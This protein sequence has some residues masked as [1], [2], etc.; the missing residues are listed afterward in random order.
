MECF[1]LIFVHFFPLLLIWFS[2]VSLSLSLSLNLL[3]VT[4]YLMFFGV[5]I[6]LNLS[7]FSGR[8]TTK[9]R[10]KFMEHTEIK[11]TSQLRTE[12][13]TKINKR[14]HSKPVFSCTSHSIC[15]I[16]IIL[17]SVCFVPWCTIVEHFH[18][19]VEHFEMLHFKFRVFFRPV[20]SIGAEDGQPLP[21]NMKRNNKLL[22]TA[23]YLWCSKM[24]CTTS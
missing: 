7:N 15:V 13:Q 10:P 14:Y 17:H 19:H 18:F 23:Y 20:H 1:R 9:T 3:F 5:F 8:Y 12:F 2:F 4:I 11:T 6:S 22:L 24:V 21:F 16:I